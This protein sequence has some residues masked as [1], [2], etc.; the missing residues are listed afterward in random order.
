[1]HISYVLSIPGHQGLEWHECWNQEGM[2]AECNITRRV[3]RHYHPGLTYLHFISNLQVGG[4]TVNA[5]DWIDMLDQCISSLTCCCNPRDDNAIEHKVI[6]KSSEWY[7]SLSWYLGSWTSVKRRQQRTLLRPAIPTLPWCCHI[8]K[9]KLCSCVGK[10]KYLFGHRLQKQH[11]VYC[12]YSE[13]SSFSSKGVCL[14]AFPIQ[15][16]GSI[17]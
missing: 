9:T 14:G 15:V 3:W 2:E 10:W 13:V 11:W 6:C 7:Q 4:H 8:I 12:W 1:M 5:G 16:N 17:G